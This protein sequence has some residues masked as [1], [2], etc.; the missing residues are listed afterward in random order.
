MRDYNPT[1]I[2]AMFSDA[3]QDCTG[4]RQE[5]GTDDGTIIRFTEVKEDMKIDM[6]EL[7]A[8]LLTVKGFLGM[9][10]CP[11]EE[12]FDTYWTAL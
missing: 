6:M 9:V 11:S 10:R 5:L 8:S 1:I 2:G 3:C 4:D 12:A 7:F